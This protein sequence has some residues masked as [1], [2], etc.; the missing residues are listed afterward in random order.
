MVYD[1]HDSSIMELWCLSAFGLDVVGSGA[2]NGVVRILL[3]QVLVVS[4]SVSVSKF[5]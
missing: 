1:G 2:G 3:M 5:V 4:V